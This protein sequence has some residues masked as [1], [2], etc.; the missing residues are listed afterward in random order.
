[1]GPRLTL[2]WV[3]ILL[4]AALGVAGEPYW[5]GER[6]VLSELFLQQI[7]ANSA[8]YPGGFPSYARNAAPAGTCAACL[9]DLGSYTPK[10]WSAPVTYAFVDSSVHPWTAEEK[11]A[12]RTAIE[13]W[14]A[15]SSPLAGRIIEWTQPSGDTASDIVLR[16][17]DRRSFFKRWGDED[18]SGAGFNAGNA[19]AYWV[20][21]AMA[22][23]FGIDPAGDI[24]ASGL[25]D[26]ADTIVLN[27]DVEW[28]VDE[29]PSVSEEFIESIATR[30][31][32]TLRVYRAAEGTDAWNAWDLVTVVEHEFGHALGLIHSGG[33]DGDPCAPRV[34]KDADFDG[35]VMWEGPLHTTRETPLEDLYVGFDE[36]VFVEAQVLADVGESLC[37]RYWTALEQE[38]GAARDVLWSRHASD[39]A[40]MD[41]VLSFEAPPSAWIAS[42]QTL[43]YLH[44]LWIEAMETFIADWSIAGE[45]TDL[46]NE[47]LRVIEED[48]GL[49]PLCCDLS[50]EMAGLVDVEDRIIVD[51]EQFD[52]W[53]R[54]ADEARS[55]SRIQEVFDAVSIRVGE[56]ICNRLAP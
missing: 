43:K 17:E 50:I 44:A 22:P 49:F 3:S 2:A 16:W 6:G 21:A 8:I 35:S 45:I 32:R 28:F 31:G 7:Y 33:C 15:V 11:A 27:A 10:S 24:L 12:A 52:E 41:R 51:P 34:R 13:A 56:L 29:T 46:F 23:S 5:G 38:V 4:I 37:D 25:W 19:I 40:I 26:R 42:E 54:I 14:S 20:P 1:M 48:R 39:A 30:C 53:D 9:S 55:R 36:R 18:G 47:A